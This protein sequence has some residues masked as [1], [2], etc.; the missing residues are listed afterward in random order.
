MKSTEINATARGFY[1]SVFHLCR[2]EHI[3]AVP[4]K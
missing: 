2:F 3:L 4:N 1:F